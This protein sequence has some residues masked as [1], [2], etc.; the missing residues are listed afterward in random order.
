MVLAASVVRA[1]AAGLNC[2]EGI[3][4]EWQVGKASLIAVCICCGPLSVI[5]GINLESQD[6]ELLVF[7]GRVTLGINPGSVQIA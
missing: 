1:D 5:R 4:L 3:V 6:G 7:I 2:A